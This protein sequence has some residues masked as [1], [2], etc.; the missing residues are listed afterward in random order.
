MGEVGD[1]LEA[2]EGESVGVT[3]NPG[4]QTPQ[5]WSQMPARGQ[6]GQSILAHAVA[7]KAS[8]VVQVLGWRSSHCMIVGLGVGL[9]L[10]FDGEEQS[11]QVLLQI[12]GSVHVGHRNMA[13]ASEFADRS[14]AQAVGSTSSHTAVE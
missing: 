9:G 8:N 1:L 7:F 6:V 11:P 14:V 13:Q 12:P 5:L 3:V 2:V 10:K 4:T